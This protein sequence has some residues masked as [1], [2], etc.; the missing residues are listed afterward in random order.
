MIKQNNEMCLS[1]M[2]FYLLIRMGSGVSLLTVRFVVC[3]CVSDHISRL[4]VHV[5]RS[6]HAWCQ[7]NKPGTLDYIL[8]DIN[9][10]SK[11]KAATEFSPGLSRF[12]LAAVNM[13]SHGAGK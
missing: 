9:Y 1:D 6:A 8:P 13:M 3:I 12:K 2:M 7:S 11:L 10:T 5:F 4:L